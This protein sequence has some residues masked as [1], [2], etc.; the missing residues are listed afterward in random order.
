LIFVPFAAA[1]LACGGSSD[2]TGPGA[3]GGGGGGGGGGT[4]PVATTTVEMKG[5]A[6][7]PGAIKVA[8]GA[9]VTWTNSDGT[10]HNVKFDN[11]TLA[12]TDFATGSKA[13]TMPTTPGTYTYKCSLH[14]GMTGS[15]QV[16]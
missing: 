4:A 13:L 8:A 7:A 9:T 15:V 1:I 2:S 16:Q 3:T 10:N 12:L 5:L 6:F 11:A 14:G